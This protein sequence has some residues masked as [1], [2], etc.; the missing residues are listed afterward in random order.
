MPLAVNV[1]GVSFSYSSDAVLKDVDLTLE[2]GNFLVIIGPN[3]GGKS[4]LLK[5]ILG[6]IPP[7]DG[8]ITV[9]GKPPGKSFI[10]YVPQNPGQLEFFPINVLD[11][12][13]LGLCRPAVKIADKRRL[14]R[15]EECLDI[16]G[17]R[18]LARERVADISSGQRQ[19]LLIARGIAAEPRLLLLDEPISQI[20]PVGQEETLSILRGL[21][22]TIIFVSHDLSV[23]P[24]FATA[25]ACVNKTL[26]FHPS[27]ELTPTLF[28]AAYGN[29]ASFALV[30]H[31]N[32]G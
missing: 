16:M 24:R 1:K 15:A 6:L 29:T 21:N 31:V 12:A 5:L 2:E 23:I 18:G 7:D 4:T 17:I 11:T 19:R 26:H 27:G 3:G 8:D 30:S 10:G 28:A 22:T 14:A 9:F 13:L 32:E 25:V 20:D